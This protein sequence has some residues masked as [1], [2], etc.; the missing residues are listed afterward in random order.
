MNEAPTM[1]QALEA[2]LATNERTKFT[3]SE[4]LHSTGEIQ[5]NKIH[6]MLRGGKSSG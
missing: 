4:S 3:P 6:L 5:T 2:Q 1:C